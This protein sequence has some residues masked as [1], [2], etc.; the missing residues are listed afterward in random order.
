MK[1]RKHTALLAAV[2]LTASCTVTALP[3]GYSVC[4][5]EQAETKR[6][7]DFQYTEQDGCITITG[8]TFSVNDARTS[9]TVPAQIDGKPVTEIGKEAFIDEAC[10]NLTEIHLP[11]SLKK[12]N[13]NAFYG[14]FSLRSLTLP[15]GL[16]TIG[17]SAFMRS[18]IESITIPDSVK[19]IGAYAFNYC[20]NLKEIKLPE[21]VTEIPLNAFMNCDA[22]EKAELSPKT[23]RIGRNA[24]GGCKS[25]KTV[26][27]PDTLES[28]YPGAMD[29]TPWLAAKKAEN[30]L[31]CSDG[32]KFLIDGT[33]CTGEVKI[34]DTV[35]RINEQ[36]F[37]ENENITSVY[38]PDSVT[39]IGM[40]AFFA[41]TALKTVRMPEKITRISDALFN[42][43]GLEEFTIPDSVKTIGMGAFMTCKSLRSVVIP[44]GVTKIDIGA[45][46]ECAALEE[47]SIP[48]SVT[49][50]GTQ[51]AAFTPWLEKQHEKNGAFVIINQNLIDIAGVS[52]T[53]VIPDGVTR[54][55]GGAIL[56][57]DS[58]GV[59]DIIVPPSVEYIGPGAFYNCTD[60]HSVTVMNPECY[61]SDPDSDENNI[62][63]VCIYNDKYQGMLRGTE[64]STVKQYAEKHEIK[65]DLASRG[66]ADGDY[67]V[68]ITDAQLVLRE[69]TNSIA[70]NP[71]TFT[72]V[73]KQ[74]ADV[75]YDGDVSVDDA[76]LILKYYVNN[77][78]AGNVITWQ[79][80]I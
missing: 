37:N 28:F 78:V 16:E 8:V 55:C 60:L 64:N 31:V 1:I 24:F 59:K 71:G 51:I 7:Q 63:D 25:L 40:G 3:A 29:D 5:E 41:C 46:L 62:Y 61:L 53:V 34:P 58:E 10:I 79:E 52:G 27:M 23:T 4:A 80:L 13:S 54:I 39:E 26:N 38:I 18:K 74:A 70:G 49:D 48:A 77:S 19:E 69:Y 44:D 75:N 22:L 15:D 72:D 35:Q 76:Q 66:D 56:E 6:W 12:I 67:A 32:G 14:C 68:S 21:S 33:A 2:L 43:S 45:F 17:T 36:A 50:I 11:D 9:V 65:F 73:Q 57:N 20:K 30:P 42:R 47:L